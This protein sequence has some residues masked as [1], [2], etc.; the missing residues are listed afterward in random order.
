VEDGQDDEGAPK[1]KKVADAF[2][3]EKATFTRWP[4]GV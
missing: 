1:Y 3:H 4:V 2:D